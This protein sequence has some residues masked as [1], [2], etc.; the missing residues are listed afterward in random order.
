M[1][2]LVR[3]VL[4]LIGV[5]LVSGCGEHREPSAP[6]Q[7]DDGHAVVADTLHFAAAGLDSAVR[8]ALGRPP[9]PIT[10]EQL[11]TLTQLDARQRGIVELHGIEALCNLTAL[12]L[13]Y[14]AIRDPAPLASLTKLQ[15]LDLSGNRVNDLAAL[16]GLT[17]LMVVLLE[18]NQV[19]SIAPLFSLPGLTRVELD[20][21][22]LAAAEV[23]RLRDRGVAVT[24][25]WQSPDWT[26]LEVHVGSSFGMGPRLVFSSGGEIYARDP[27]TSSSVNLTRSTGNDLDP[28]FTPDGA[29]FAFASDR[30][31][32]FEIYVLRAR[33]G[34]A[35][36][37]TNCP[38]ADRAPAWSMTGDRIAFVSD[39]D[40]NREIY[41]ASADGGRQIN[42]TANWADD[43]EPVWSPDSERLAFTS[44][45]YG[46]TDIWIMDYD[47]SNAANLTRS[48]TREKMP[49]WAPDGRR[50]AYLAEEAAGV[51]VLQVMDL[52]G[53]GPA[54]SLARLNEYGSGYP[55]W[56]SDGTAIYYLS[57]GSLCSVYAD[58][59]GAPPPPLIW[60]GSAQTP[61]RW[62]PDISS[63]FILGE[64][65]TP[66]LFADAC[67]EA[68]VRSTIIIPEEQPL[69]QLDLVG[70]T[71]LV[72]RNCGIA[73]L[74]GIE[75]ID[76]LRELNLMNAATELS[77][78]PSRDWN[79]IR[80]LTP[81]AGLPGLVDA[82]LAL[83]AGPSLNSMGVT[84]L[85]GLRYLS[86]ADGP[87]GSLAA[88]ASLTQLSSLKLTGYEL[89]D[90]T[91]LG[92][93]DRL[94]ELSLTG[95]LITDLRPLATLANLTSL[96]V[97]QSQVQDLRPLAGLSR[98]RSL[99]LSGNR[100]VEIEP[101][102]QMTV[103]RRLDLS[104]NQV[105][106]LSALR[107]LPA[108]WFLYVA[109]NPLNHTAR[110]EVIPALRAKGVTVTE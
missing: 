41:A 12:D 26:G 20:G 82:S 45:R 10:P 71:R 107:N 47:G 1:K 63:V 37:I 79:R 58:G 29:G 30:S 54:K 60:S 93:L 106:D 99:T 85:T 68:A 35:V 83:G 86:L 42:L 77:A 51:W 90:L 46:Q 33:G 95:G 75:Q 80:D 101:L 74:R 38:A 88:L 87:L 64:A 59:S 69:S 109:G 97:A 22:P 34:L 73:D 108:L 25:S 91:P 81:L 4:L 62:V 70:L 27:Q 17:S 15:Y 110:N 61:W 36:N 67:L 53:T 5:L 32:D 40:G 14:N 57:S 8:A 3:S 28:A 18:Q 7:P 52:D 43:Y 72:C 24:F 103:L 92:S 78:A 102:R 6:L 84:R 56:S 9:G 105:E 50:L 39:R 21:N 48:E 98:L 55:V 49:A 13:S 31:G 2:P 19:P 16:S 65:L 66:T 44:E 76:G 23:T 11:L 96:T 94:D 104:N 100:I 89:A